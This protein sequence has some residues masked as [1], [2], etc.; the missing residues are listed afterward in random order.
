MVITS[1]S[2]NNNPVGIVTERDILKSI[3]YPRT[4]S[5]TIAIE[6]IMSKPV[7]SVGADATLEMQYK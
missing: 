5:E 2:D 6:E 3:A 1:K 4:R 7:I